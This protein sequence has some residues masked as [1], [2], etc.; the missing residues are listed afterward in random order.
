MH[1]PVGHGIVSK[2]IEEKALVR[3]NWGTM[4]NIA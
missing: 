1:E 4:S 2:A 3:N